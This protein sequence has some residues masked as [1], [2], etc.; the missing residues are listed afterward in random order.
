MVTT[1]NSKSLMGSVFLPAWWLGRKPTDRILHASHTTSLVEGFSRQARNLI[2]DEDYRAIF[3]NTVL[4]TEVNRVEEW[5][6]VPPKGRRIPGKYACAGVGTAIAGKRGNL[7]IIDDPISEQTAWSETARNS[8]NNWFPGGFR[9]RM[10]PGGCIVCIATRWHEDDLLGWLL[11][12]AQEEDSEQWVNIDL[13]AIL[14]DDAAKL[15]GDGAQAGEALFPELYDLEEMLSIKKE[16][17]SWQWNALYMQRPTNEEGA[18]LKRDYWVEWG[19][20]TPPEKFTDSQKKAWLDGDYPEFVFTLQSWDTAFSKA[21]HADF[22]ACTTWG[23]FLDQEKTP[24]Q[25]LCGAMKGRWDFPELVQKSLLAYQKWEPTNVLIEKKASGQSLWQELHHRGLPVSTYRP[26]K[27]KIA[28]AN[29]VSG[30]LHGGRTYF[31]P[32]QATEDCIEECAA[33]PFGKHD[34][35][36]DSVTQAL[37]RLR[38]GRYSQHPEDP[39]PDTRVRRP[40]RRRSY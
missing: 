14:D 39:K 33:F 18:I 30:I 32:R 37:W 20:G 6:I 7:G 35:F 24:H 13:P 4:S 10:L 8:V 1:H 31:M 9:S 38:E 3:P 5:E 2:R 22:S 23:V 17:P 29:A 28:R 27:D 16:M 25:M 40:R 19:H 12:R 15:L 21:D 11:R 26:D 36:V 34:D